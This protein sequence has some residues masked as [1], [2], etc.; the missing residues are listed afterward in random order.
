MM[1]SESAYYRRESIRLENFELAMKYEFEMHFWQD[2]LEE[3]RLDL[4][5][6]DSFIDACEEA[7]LC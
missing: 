4:I 3:V 1:H 6:N 2:R 7:F 5:N